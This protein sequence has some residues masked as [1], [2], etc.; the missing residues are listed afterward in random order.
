ML[1][2]LFLF[3]NF[4]PFLYDVPLFFKVSFGCFLICFILA[5]PDLA[6]SSDATLYGKTSRESPSPYWAKGVGCTLPVSCSFLFYSIYNLSFCCIVVISNCKYL[7][8]LKHLATPFS[9][10]LLSTSMNLTVFLNIKQ[11]QKIM[12]S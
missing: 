1:L 2:D 11:W 5:K 6:S 8:G 12:F 9:W 4:Q 10:L 3:G 7:E